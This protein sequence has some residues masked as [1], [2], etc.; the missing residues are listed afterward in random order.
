MKIIPAVLGEHFDDFLL[1]LRQAEPFTDYVEIDLMDGIFVPTKSF[2]VE[3]INGVEMSLSFQAHLMAKDPADY[4]NRLTHPRLKTVIFHFESQTAPGDMVR[5]IRERGL[6]AGLAINPETQMDQFKEAAVT[7]DLLQ[8]L[9]VEPGNYG[10]PFRREVLKKI[11][12]TRRLFPYKVISVDGGVSLENLKSF[13]D[14]GVDRACIGSRIFLNGNPAENY[15]Q[16]VE[17]VMGL[18]TEKIIAK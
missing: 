2:E 5:R 13:L 12:E 9:T 11:E 18:E 10:M 17:R 14:I 4:L 8:F 3:R 6:E 7:V 1:R 15:R 16:F